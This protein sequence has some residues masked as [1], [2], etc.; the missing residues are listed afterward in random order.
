MDASLHSCKLSCAKRLEEIDEV[1]LDEVVEDLSIAGALGD[2]A[3]LFHHRPHGAPDD[4][5]LDQKGLEAVWLR[6]IAHC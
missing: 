3:I 6:K 5:D 4:Q 2:S 1:C